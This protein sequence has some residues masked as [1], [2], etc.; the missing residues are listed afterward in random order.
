VAEPDDAG[1]DDF[2]DVPSFE[3][4]GLPEG[5]FVAVA[6]SDEAEGLPG[7]AEGADAGAVRGA[8]DV[9]AFRERGGAG[10]LGL[11]EENEVIASEEGDHVGV[12][13]EAGD[14]RFGGALG[15]LE[16]NGVYLAVGALAGNGLME[17]EEALEHGDGLEACVAVGIGAGEMEGEFVAGEQVEQ[18]ETKDGEDVVRELRGEGAGALEDIVDVGLGDAGEA[19]EAALGQFTVV[20]AA[21]EVLEEA[22]LNDLEGERGDFHR[23]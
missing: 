20:D 15:E 22:F 19:G 11:V 13:S 5:L 12:G 18:R 17:A 7:E 1:E 23:K 14:E 2:E 16:G 21:A 8:D 6:V 3:G 9:V 4:E 10:C